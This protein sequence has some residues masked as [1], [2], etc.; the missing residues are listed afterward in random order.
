ML[1]MDFGIVSKT[2]GKLLIVESAFLFFPLT[3]SLYYKGGDTRAFILTIIITAIAGFILNMHKSKKGI[4]RYREGF[5][6][7]SLGWLLVSI[8]G[9]FPFLIAGTFDT[10]I[11]AFFETVSGF[12][13]TGATV[14]TNIE[15]QPHGILFWRAFTHWLGG[16]GIL[17]FT[18]ALI[19]TMGLSNLN[20]L[21]AESPGPTP[22]KLVPKIAKTAQLLYIIY[23]TL[24]VAEVI[25][26]KIAGMSLFDAVTH[27]FATMGTGGFSTK[28]LSIGAYAMPSYEWIIIGFMIL[29]GANFS[30]YYS[31]LV[32]NIKTL[33]KDREFQF[34]IAVILIS[35]VL[36]TI[37]ITS[38][39]DDLALTFRQAS[40]QV[41]SIIST[42]GFTSLDYSIWPP[43]SKM[44]LFVLM[45]FGGCA[46][47]TGGAIK[48]V[49][50]LVIFK[51][52]KRELQ[53][54][55]HPNSVISIRMGGKVIPENVVQNI[56]GFVL[57]YMLLFVGFSVILVT[58]NLDLVSSTSAVA[59]T[60]GNVGPGF[61]VVG[62]AMNYNG[63]TV[64]TKYV[65]SL[66][67]ILGRLEIFTVLIIFTPFF[68]QE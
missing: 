14:L 68:W 45:F 29:A 52:V 21:K 40:F 15:M 55:I 64:L 27:T 16:M 20:I 65:L 57:I 12:T 8:F 19:P 32:G 59:A 1:T 22:S 58:Q 48:Q 44:I 25:A 62:P 49:R 33:F 53:K 60:L 41:A 6:I 42:T 63:L 38:A 46:G 39:W 3:V 17:V 28:N 34:F 36:I 24:T 37:N 7:V 9:A 5:M 18:L 61:G 50:I 47:S 23:F 54:L 4:V 11:N 2:L 31:V 30:L 43:F 26:L 10:F 13:T 35:T 56:V 51:Y 67:M 66:A